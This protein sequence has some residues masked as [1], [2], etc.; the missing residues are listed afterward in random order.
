[1]GGG[2]VMSRASVGG[3]SSNYLVQ[4]AFFLSLRPFSVAESLCALSASL[5]ACLAARQAAVGGVLPWPAHAAR[6]ASRRVFIAALSATSSFFLAS[7]VR[8]PFLSAALSAASATRSSAAALASLA[9]ASV[10]ACVGAVTVS[11]VAVRAWVDSVVA[12]DR[13]DPS[14]RAVAGATTNATATHSAA[15]PEPIVISLRIV[16]SKTP[17]EVAL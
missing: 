16:N 13:C 3:G 1:M 11:T 8:L 5:S 4:A 17:L 6:A 9:R 15:A 7:L 12:C 10:H 2:P 14:A